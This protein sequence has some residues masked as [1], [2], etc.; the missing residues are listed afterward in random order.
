MDQHLVA[1]VEY[2]YDEFEQPSVRV[3]AESELR[4][5]TVVVLWR[6]EHTQFWAA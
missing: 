2:K 6:S 1:T 3:E 4:H 5:R